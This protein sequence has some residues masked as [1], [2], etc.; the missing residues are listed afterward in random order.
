MVPAT[1][2]NN[3]IRHSAI[4]E[5]SGPVCQRMIDVTTRNNGGKRSLE[6]IIF[7]Y[8]FFPLRSLNVRIRG[9]CMM[10]GCMEV[11][12]YFKIHIKHI[13]KQS[14]LDNEDD[15]SQL[16]RIISGGYTLTDL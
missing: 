3:I 12:I 16:V 6:S 10:Y 8:I 9:T 2:P 1:N 4:F 11:K 15:N 13:R 5:F 14:P 7:Q